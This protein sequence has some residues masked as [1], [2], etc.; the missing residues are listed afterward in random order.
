MSPDIF[1]TDT[2]TSSDI[3]VS[4]SSDIDISTS[5]DI[6]IATDAALS[7]IAE[8]TEVELI[9]PEIELIP[10]STFTVTSGTTS[11]FLDFPLLESAAGITLVDVDSIGCKDIWRH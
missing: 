5:S 9:T 10:P 6:D 11:V 2:S 4:S 8:E 7:P 3:A 1:T